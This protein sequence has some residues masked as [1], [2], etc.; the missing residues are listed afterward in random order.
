[1]QFGLNEMGFPSDDRA[2]AATLASDAGYDGIEPNLSED[3]AL[4]SSTELEEV[5]E[6]AETNGLAIPSVSTLHFWEY[7]LSSTDESI[8]EQGLECGEQLIDAATELGAE[9]A[10]VVPGVVDEETPY[11]VAYE[12]ALASVQRLASYGG[13]RDV[14]IALEN[15]WNDF[16]L[17]PLEFRSFVDGAAESGP[18]GVY[19]DVGNVRRFG[20]PSQ[21]IRILGDRIDKIH[22][23]D[24]DTDVDTIDGFTYPLQ[25]DVDW[26][27]VSDAL[28]ELGYD[29]W[30]T[31]EVPPYETGGDRMPGQVLENVRS[32]L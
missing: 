4:D 18:V 30:V 10:L 22:V 9:T 28:E 21:W 8:R 5:A 17:S 14:T 6:I 2:S 3:G 24:Y 11:D 20:Y 25:G 31:A 19:F 23:K 32:V 12:N 26:T 15:V 16:L 1:M 29:G 7:P 27:A 13:C